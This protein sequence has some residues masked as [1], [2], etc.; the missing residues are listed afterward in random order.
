VRSFMPVRDL[1]E[2]GELVEEE[3]LP[4]PV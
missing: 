2:S 1:R 3:P 4:A